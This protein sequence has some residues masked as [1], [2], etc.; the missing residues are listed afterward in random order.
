[1]SN[2]LALE[3]SPYL[4][5]HA[6]NPVDWHPWGEEAFALARAQDR[7]VHLSVGYAA[8]HWCH[9]MAHES[10]EDPRVA[11]LLN[12]TFINIK[13]DRQERPDLD[14]IYQKVVQ[15][16]GEGGGWPLTVFLT[17]EGEPFYGGTY[18]PPQDRHGRPGLERLVRRIAQ[19]W[20]EDR[21][22]LERSR[23]ELRKGFDHLDSELSRTRPATA[24]DAPAEGAR[25]L[26]LAS[27]PVHGGLGGAPKFPN[28]P[29]LDLALRVFGRTREPALWQFVERALDAMASGG[30][31]DQLGGGFSRYSVDER[32]AVPHFEKMLYDNA[33]LLGLYADALRESPRED[34][35]RILRE[36]A[37]YLL[38]DLRHPLGGFYSGEDADSEGEEGRF[39]VWTPA[40]L[41]E[42]LGEDDAAL[43]E[44]AF[45]VTRSGNFEHG[46]TV[47]QRTAAAATIAPAHLSGI[48]ERLLAHR[49]RRPRPMRDENVLAAWNGLA[50]Q[51]LCAAWQATGD[52]P[53]LEAAV[54]AAAFVDSRMSTPQGGLHRA[55]R[56]GRAAGPGFLDDCANMANAHLDLYESAL[57]RHHLDRALA[58][59]GFFLSRFWDEGFFLT[60]ADGEALIRRPRSIHDHAVPSGGAAATRALLRLAAI[61]GDTRMT[62]LASQS[63]AQLAGA[64][65]QNPFGHAHLLAA[66]ELQHTMVTIVLAGDVGPGDE[67][68]L[69]AHGSYL[70]GRTIARAADSPLG[71]AMLAIGGRTT[72][73]VCRGSTCSPPVTGA[74]ELERLL[75]AG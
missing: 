6:E 45:A 16:L 64:A 57:A 18:F 47:L 50:I 49:N 8:C 3:T 12:E 67:L 38:R 10:F 43:A 5:Q 1:M 13:V 24:I 27:D 37:A 71:A 53:L 48:R 21:A 34:W 56:D 32:W 40:Q 61:T 66:M 70:P 15:L 55:W 7:P 22:E 35:L 46:A 42:V 2:R 51:G 14:D 31:F 9:V 30:L 75:G 33:L 59:A 4:Q 62:A 17:P 20:R 26:A 65:Q 19:L 69:T 73:Y 39:Y 41:R 74:A 29:C 72:A 25:A 23:D 54:A 68:L 44:R 36:T 52:A 58:L 60:P 11:A 63:I 28:V